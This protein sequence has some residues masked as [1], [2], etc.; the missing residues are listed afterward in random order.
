MRTRR[1]PAAGPKIV[2]KQVAQQARDYLR[3]RGWRI[4]RTQFAFSPGSFSTGEPGMADDLAVFYVDQNRAVALALWLEYKGPNDRR[5]CTC[6]PGSGKPCHVCRQLQWHAPERPG[7]TGRNAEASPNSTQ[8]NGAA[9]LTRT[10]PR[11][12]A[13]RGRATHSGMTMH[14]GTVPSGDTLRP[15]AR[16]SGFPPGKGPQ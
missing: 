2:E 3:A 10:K 11:I 12:A 15:S 7:M 9:R 13:I 6:Q 8:L 4:V 14:N 16:R 5:R 1:A